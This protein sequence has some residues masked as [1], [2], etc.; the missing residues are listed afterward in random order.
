[1]WCYTGTGRNLESGHKEDTY[2]TAMAKRRS[3]ET[4][5][6]T[7]PCGILL[8]MAF[9]RRQTSILKRG[10]W[11]VNSIR[12]LSRNQLGLWNIPGLIASDPTSANVLVN[13]TVLP[14]VSRRIVFG[15]KAPGIWAGQTALTSPRCGWRVKLQIQKNTRGFGDHLTNHVKSPH[16]PGARPCRP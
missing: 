8:I 10:L 5:K 11:Q 9:S 12:T 16:I 14:E 7:R 3:E 1:M 15:R 2:H 6:H 13:G 4:R